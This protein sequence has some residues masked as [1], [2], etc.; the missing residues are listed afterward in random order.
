MAARLR[1]PVATASVTPSNGGW[2]GGRASLRGSETCL[3]PTASTSPNPGNYRVRL[4]RSRRRRPTADA[5]AVAQ[6]GAGEGDRA[7]RTRP[8]VKIV[9]HDSRG[10]V[11]SRDF[12][13][14]DPLV[15]RGAVRQPV[16]S[17]RLVL[18]AP[19]LSP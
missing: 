1:R 4:R 6:P 13:V 8:D 17:C 11:R 19:R 16:R 10:R 5:T 7:G 2:G 14:A 3:R 18:A 15:R 12:A 9:A